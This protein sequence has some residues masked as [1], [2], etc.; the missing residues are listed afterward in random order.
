MDRNKSYM[1]CIRN[2]DQWG[3]GWLQSK[4]TT[5][6]KVIAWEKSL[7]FDSLFAGQMEVDL[8]VG[9]RHVDTVE[10]EAHLVT[11]ALIEF[12]IVVFGH[13]PSELLRILGSG[14]FPNVTESGSNSFDLK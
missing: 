12:E 10:T 7:S 11:G 6:S 14:F 1:N 8:L 5:K 9:A 4:F 3:V 13:V 2:E